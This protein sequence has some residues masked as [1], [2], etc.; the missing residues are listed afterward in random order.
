VRVWQRRRERIEGQMDTLKPILVTGAPRSGTTWVGRMLAEAPGVFYIHEPFNLDYPP[1]LGICDARFK[2]WFTHITRETDAQYYR[3]IRNTLAFRYNWAGA[4]SSLRTI[5]DARKTIAEGH[6][7]IDQRRRR[8]VP[9][10]KD[11]IALFSAEWLSERFGMQV[12]MMIR[13]PAAFV[14]SIKILNW[15][16]PF[17]HFLSQPHLMR[18]FLQP[19][20]G[21]IRQYANREHPIFDQ[22]ILL[23]RLIY[24]TV[25]VLRDQHKG[26][27][28]LRHEDLSRNPIG[29]FRDVFDRLGL[30]F[31]D[32]VPEV[33]TLYSGPENPTQPF[34]HIGTESA[35]KRNSFSNISNWKRRLSAAEIAQIR[36]LVEPLSSRFY[37]EEDW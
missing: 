22:A 5:E 20:E 14:S 31:A 32:H 1:S 28:Y 24:H 33:I 18:T 30:V 21:E 8:S 27:V 25:N 17:S 16:H 35:L 37:S 29:S 3:A 7:F 9:L 2:Y 26:W 19:F 12:V 13:H 36:D 34:E 4:L 6:R 10:I 11:P 23:W 15:S